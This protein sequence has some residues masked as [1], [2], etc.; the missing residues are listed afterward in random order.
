LEGSDSGTTVSLGWQEMIVVG[1]MARCSAAEH[2]SKSVKGPTPSTAASKGSPTMT[3]A[4][5]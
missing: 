2:V 5:A 4:S 3:E 1:S